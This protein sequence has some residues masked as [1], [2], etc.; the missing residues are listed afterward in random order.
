MA[1]VMMANILPYLLAFAYSH[2][3]PRHGVLQLRSGY[4]RA[5]GAVGVVL[6]HARLGVRRFVTVYLLCGR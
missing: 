1:I 3:F 4:D 5:P 2:A 6:T